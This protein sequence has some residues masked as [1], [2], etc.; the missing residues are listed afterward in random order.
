M[1]NEITKTT[2]A[3]I[4]K[5]IKAALE[6]H[7]TVAIDTRKDDLGKRYGFNAASFTASGALTAKARR[8]VESIARQIKKGFSTIVNVY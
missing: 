1:K 5:E 8:N 4:A 6:G 2:V 3:G 7:R